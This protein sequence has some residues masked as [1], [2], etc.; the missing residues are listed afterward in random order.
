MMLKAQHFLI[1]LLQF[2]VFHALTVIYICH[3]RM[4]QG[5]VRV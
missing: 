3:E 1:I 5:A 4:V 2:T